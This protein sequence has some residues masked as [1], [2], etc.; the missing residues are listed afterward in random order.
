MNPLPYAG[1]IGYPAAVTRRPAT[2]AL[3]VLVAAAAVLVVVLLAT[4]VIGLVRVT[5][6]RQGVSIRETQRDVQTRQADAAAAKQRED[7]HNAGL[8]TK[9]Q[10]VKD[11]DKAL[12]TV[13]AEWHTGTLHFGVLNQAINDCDDAV[14]D[15]DRAAAPFPDSLLGGLPRRI[16]L[17]NPETDCGRSF[18]SSI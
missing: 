11:L 10:R 5:H 9:L 1:P 3:Q 4:A 8:D 12:D 14:D 16:N 2:R 13:F 17:N 7:Y 15:Y 18:T 6:L